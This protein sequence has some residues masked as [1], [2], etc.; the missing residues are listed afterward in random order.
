MSQDRRLDRLEQVFGA[1]DGPTPGQ[2]A[3]IQWLSIWRLTLQKR[4]Y[5]QRVGREDLIDLAE[6]LQDILGDPAAFL[7]ELEAQGITTLESF[8]N[9]LHERAHQRAEE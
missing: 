2:W 8:L 6:P 7:A 9:H 5:L 3:I 1:T 4:S